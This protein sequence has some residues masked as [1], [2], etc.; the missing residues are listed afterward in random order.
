LHIISLLLNQLQLILDC[1][2]FCSL[3]HCTRS[4]KKRR[5]SWRCV[6]DCL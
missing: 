4:R 1:C 2:L 3:Q 5:T 6:E